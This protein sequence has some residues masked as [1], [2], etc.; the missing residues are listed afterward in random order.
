M[1]GRPRTAFTKGFA[2]RMRPETFRALGDL[3]RSTGL[4]KG[5]ICRVALEQH[6]AESGL[7]DEKELLATYTTSKETH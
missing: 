5:H 6:L 3:T 7:L 4:S 1:H 2:F